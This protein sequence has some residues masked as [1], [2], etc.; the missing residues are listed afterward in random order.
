MTV[1]KV[2]DDYKLIV[3]KGARDNLGIVPGDALVFSYDFTIDDIARVSNHLNCGVRVRKSSA[4]GGERRVAEASALYDNDQVETI[5]AS[6]ASIQIPPSL[7]KDLTLEPGSLVAFVRDEISYWM[8]PL[9]RPSQ[10]LSGTAPTDNTGDPFE[11]IIMD[12]SVMITREGRRD[13]YDGR[14]YVVRS[15]NDDPFPNMEP[16]TDTQLLDE[17]Q[18][19]YGVPT[20]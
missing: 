19:T 14:E 16:F 8:I 9:I 17:F 2:S 13:N 10:I 7:V 6:D 11:D 18:S 15:G 3:P 4:S 1:A 5:V 12:Y 20:L